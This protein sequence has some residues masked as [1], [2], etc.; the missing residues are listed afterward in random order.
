MRRNRDARE[1]TDPG[2]L[3]LIIRLES[4]HDNEDINLNDACIELGGFGVGVRESRV[5]PAALPGV[6]FDSGGPGGDDNIA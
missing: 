5:V 3:V 4:D 2:T 6:L 1:E